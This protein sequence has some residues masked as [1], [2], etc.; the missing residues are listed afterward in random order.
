[1]LGLIILG[2]PET[3]HPV[4]LRYKA[5]KLRKETGDE[6]WKTPIEVMQRSIL[7]TIVRSCYRL[8]FFFFFCVR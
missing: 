2:V 4:L 3:Y 6:M 8:F 5:L 7:Q 1:M